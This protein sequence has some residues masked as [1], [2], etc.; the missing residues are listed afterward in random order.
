MAVLLAVS[1]GLQIV[2]DRGYDAYQPETSLL[3]LQAGPMLNR[4]TLGYGALLADLYWMRAVVYYGGE[5]RGVE[6]KG[7]YALLGPLLDVV[8]TADPRFSVAYRFGAVFLTEAYPNGPGRPDLSINLLERGIRND[9]GRWEYMHDIAFVYYWWLHDYKQAAEW[10]SRAAKAPGAPTWLEPLA[11]TTLAVGGDRQSSRT[12]WR[13]LLESTDIDWIR[14]NAE[15]RLLQLDALDA[16]DQLNAIALRY[17]ERNGRPAANWN[18]LVQ[19]ERLRG[20]PLDPTGTPFEIDPATGRIGLS[21]KSPLWPPPQEPR[22]PPPP[23][24]DPAPP[25]SRPS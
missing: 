24:P 9:G 10:F 23:A 19:G 2:R 25:A 3:W 11:A 17:L 20:V 16:I 18:E 12:L 1:I 6:S 14:Q 7:R 21:P 5:R 4:M 13:E 15:R 8:V 22:M